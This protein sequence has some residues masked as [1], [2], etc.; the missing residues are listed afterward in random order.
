MLS[1]HD[2]HKF[3][4]TIMHIKTPTFYGTSSKK[5]ITKDKDLKG[6]KSHDFHVMMQ[7]ICPYACGALCQQVV[8]C[9]LCAYVVFSTS[10]VARLWIQHNLES[11]KKK[12]RFV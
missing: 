2:K 1:D 12:W 7:N 5:R 9:Q 8:G 6:M 11:S 4:H 3:I 10:Y